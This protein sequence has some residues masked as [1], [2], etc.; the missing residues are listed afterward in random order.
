MLDRNSLV[1]NEDGLNPHRQIIGDPSDRLGDI[2]AEPENVA[3]VAHGDGKPYRRLAVHPELRL[4]RVHK[5]A[6]NARDV[7][8]AKPAS[9]DCEVDSRY[10]LFGTER[11]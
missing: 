1:G 6:V 8:E 7:A 11:T 9:A 4:G 10:V 2:V 5:A 3:A